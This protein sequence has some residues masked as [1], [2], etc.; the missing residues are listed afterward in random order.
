[1]MRHALRSQ[2]EFLLQDEAA[3]RETWPRIRT[4][5]RVSG[6]ERILRGFNCPKGSREPAG[7]LKLRRLEFGA[8]FILRVAVSVRRLLFLAGWP[9]VGRAGFL[10]GM[11]NANA[12]RE[13]QKGCRGPCHRGLLDCSR[14]L[15]RIL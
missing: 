9:V 4:R 11:C 15:T 6:L 2:L 14:N 5:S 12:N 13:N 8:E 10:R 3:G 7:K 1:A